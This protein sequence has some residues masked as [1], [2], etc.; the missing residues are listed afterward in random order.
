MLPP[1][2]PEVSCN[3]LIFFRVTMYLCLPSSSYLLRGLSFTLGV[4][5]LMRKCMFFLFINQGPKYE[6]SLMEGQL[7]SY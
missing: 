5:I 6:A 2:G 7:Y 3:T 1:P 4:S